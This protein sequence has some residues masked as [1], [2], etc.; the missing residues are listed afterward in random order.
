MH[1]VIGIKNGVCLIRGDNSHYTEEVPLEDV[2]GVM[3]GFY[4]GRRYVA[5][6][7]PGYRLFSRVWVLL[8]PLL[9]AA[10]RVRARLR[11]MAGS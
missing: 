6:A 5:A 8:A 1:R 7:A 11:Q 9:P 4:R 2:F 10:K 3:E